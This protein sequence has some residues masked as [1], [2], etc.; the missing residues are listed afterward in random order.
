MKKQLDK[1]ASVY[2]NAN[3]VKYGTERSDTMASTPHTPQDAMEGGRF[4]DILKSVPM[5]Q[6]NIV[7]LM[8][9]AFINGMKA[10]EHLN[11]CHKQSA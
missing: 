1:Y 7:A 10:Q 6:Q 9:E 8:A 11:A 3:R 4:Y 2:Y 5:E